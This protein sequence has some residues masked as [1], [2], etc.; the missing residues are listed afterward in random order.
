[1]SA[2][3]RLSGSSSGTG[4][5]ASTL[6]DPSQA[7]QSALVLLAYTVLFVALALGR[8]RTRDVTSS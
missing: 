1:V 4:P 5:A 6:P 3:A 7:G 2:I 8:F